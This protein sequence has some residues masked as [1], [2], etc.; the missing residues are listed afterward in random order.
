MTIERAADTIVIPAG[1]IVV[2][3]PNGDSWQVNWQATEDIVISRNGARETYAAHL[4]RLARA[5]RRESMWIKLL[6]TLAIGVNT[7]VAFGLGVWWERS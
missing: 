7:A 5:E 3:D 4:A 6:I 2:T 1:I